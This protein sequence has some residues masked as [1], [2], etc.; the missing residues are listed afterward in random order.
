MTAAYLGERTYHMVVYSLEL[1]DTKQK[2]RFKSHF[3]AVVEAM[4]MHEVSK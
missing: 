1:G 4:G 2:Y 3:E